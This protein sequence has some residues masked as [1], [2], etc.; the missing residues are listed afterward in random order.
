M[1]HQTCKGC[2]NGFDGPDKG[3]GYN[4]CPSC[5]RDE[6]ITDLRRQ[7][8]EAKRP[9]PAICAYCGAEIVT[10][11]N[12]A[13][14]AEVAA[15]R[16]LTIDHVR[17]CPASPWKHLATQ[18]AEA[19]ERAEKSEAACAFWQTL[20]VQGCQTCNCGPNGDTS[21]SRCEGCDDAYDHHQPIDNP[22]QPLLDQ[23]AEQGREIERLRAELVTANE[24]AA[25]MEQA[26]TEVLDELNIPCDMDGGSPCVPCW[27]ARITAL[28]GA[29][30][31]LADAMAAKDKADYVRRASLQMLDPLNADRD[32]LRAELALL[33]QP[34]KKHNDCHCDDIRATLQLAINQGHLPASIHDGNDTLLA[35][36]V[37][38]FQLASRAEA[39]EALKGKKE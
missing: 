3:I 12:P 4:L 11:Q 5:T 34:G 9:M 33:R 17:N 22:G 30:R 39:V 37:A 10:V 16:T 25:R 23:R 6:E 14:E 24:R 19:N 31:Q 26:Y 29:E 27:K 32:R 15:A 18:L 36:L 20:S 13:D 8:A 35:K 38:V 7:L 2:L 21:A 1:T 28:L